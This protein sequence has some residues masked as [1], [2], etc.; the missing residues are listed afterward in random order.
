[1]SA[2][3]PQDIKQ[4][5]QKALNESRQLLTVELIAHHHNRNEPGVT[6]AIE[7]YVMAAISHAFA[8]HPDLV[9]LRETRENEQ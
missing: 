6:D 1:M 7:R 4:R 9:R 2:A 8:T 5:T 3:G